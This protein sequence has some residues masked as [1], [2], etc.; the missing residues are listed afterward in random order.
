MI[1]GC[2]KFSLNKSVS[3]TKYSREIDGPISSCKMLNGSLIEFILNSTFMLIK[4]VFRTFSAVPRIYLTRKVK[5]ENP[6]SNRKLETSAFLIGLNREQSAQA[7]GRKKPK[8]PKFE[9][10]AFAKQTC[11]N[12]E[13]ISQIC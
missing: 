4:T 6:R 10:N 7:V 5:I 9:L 13:A 2:N 11:L 12:F 8:A 3:N 1:C